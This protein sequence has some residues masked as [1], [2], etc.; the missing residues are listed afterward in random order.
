MCGTADHSAA[1]ERPR[2]ANDR[3]SLA[4]RARVDPPATSDPS[5]STPESRRSSPQSSLRHPMR[6]L[7]VAHQ[8]GRGACRPCRQRQ[9]ATSHSAACVGVASLVGRLRRIGRLLGRVIGLAVVRAQCVRPHWRAAPKCLEDARLQR[10]RD[11]AQVVAAR[12]GALE[13]G[14]RGGRGPHAFVRLATAGPLAPRSAG[15]GP[16]TARGGPVRPRRR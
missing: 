13:E 15:H 9:P 4:R 8:H 2:T 11:R 14:G 3:S 7:R 16:S 5:N 12:S 10:R 1:T 6:L